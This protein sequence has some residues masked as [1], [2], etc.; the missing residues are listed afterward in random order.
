[1]G[2]VHCDFHFLR[3]GVRT[4]CSGEAG[5]ACV[6]VLRDRRSNGSRDDHPNL[7]QWLAALVHAFVAI[8]LAG[9]LLDR[10]DAGWQ[11]SSFDAGCILSQYN[12]AGEGARATRAS[13]YIAGEGAR[14]TRAYP[15]IATNSIGINAP[16]A[17]PIFTFFS[18]TGACSPIKTCTPIVGGPEAFCAIIRCM[19][20]MANCRRSR[21][22]SMR[23]PA[24]SSACR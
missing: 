19:N 9:E 4:L 20:S 18:I 1:H 6:V 14:A 8:E 12:A 10:A 15:A 22:C 2:A 5:E 3:V 17:M 13:N 7:E 11:A 24:A 16:E 21:W 23:N